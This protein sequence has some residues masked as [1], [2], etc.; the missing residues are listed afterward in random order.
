MNGQ[1]ILTLLNKLMKS[2]EY[3]IF[4]ID[5]TGSKWHRETN[6]E[7][8]K[9]F[10]PESYPEASKYG[11]FIIG[12]SQNVSYIGIPGRFLK[13]EQPAGGETGFTLWQPLRGGCEF[14]DDLESM[15]DEVQYIY[16]YWI[17]RIDAKTLKIGEV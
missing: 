10:C 5:E 15:G 9:K 7:V 11:H 3:G 17:A 2:D 14:Y 16:G 6:V 12:N 1:H 8:L 13:E 4:D